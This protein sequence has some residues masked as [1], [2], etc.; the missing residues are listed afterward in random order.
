M[1]GTCRKLGIAALLGTVAMAGGLGGCSST[2]A[3]RVDCNVVKL[4]QQSGRSDSEIAAAVGA[5]ESDVAACK[6]GTAEKTGN[7]ESGS[8]P[9][10]Y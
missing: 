5:S 10:N 3:N 4:Q 6:A 8:M 9:S 1:L 7:R 2:G